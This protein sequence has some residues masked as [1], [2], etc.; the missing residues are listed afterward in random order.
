MTDRALDAEIAAKVF[1]HAVVGTA[2]CVHVEGEWSI[3]V[4]SD[5]HGWACYAETGPVYVQHC[6]CE[7]RPYALPVQEN[8]SDED[9]AWREEHDA[10]TARDFESDRARFGH[11]RYCL[12]VV[13]EYS[14]DI[15]AAFDVLGCFPHW[16]L[17]T[18]HEGRT[19]NFCS[20]YQPSHPFTSN[21]VEHFT[22]AETPALAICRA[23][24]KAAEAWAKF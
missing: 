6:T 23:A 24:L 19:G 11:S 22:E 18:I 16:S 9:R 12:A 13:S 1:G 15:A 21:L 5:P 7:R 10:K 14:T 3:H 4:D 8:E 17:R 20:I 2:T